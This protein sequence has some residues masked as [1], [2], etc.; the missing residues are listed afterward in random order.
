MNKLP[1]V[2]LY[3]CTSVDTLAQ[4][5]SGEA[6]KKCF[7]FVDLT[8]CA[9]VLC[10]GK[11]YENWVAGKDKEV[12]PHKSSLHSRRSRPSMKIRKKS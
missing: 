3:C 6:K 9:A 4:R 10:G 11:I 1:W 12:T 5:A 2:D 8:R 7:I